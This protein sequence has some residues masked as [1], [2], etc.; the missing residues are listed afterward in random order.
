MGKSKKKEIHIPTFTTQQSKVDVKGKLV[1][2]ITQVAVL[3][4]IAILVV[5]LGIIIYQA[6]EKFSWEFIS[7]FP[8]NGMTEC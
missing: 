1:V 5:I 7:T 8:T 2:G 4:I 3:L 6:R